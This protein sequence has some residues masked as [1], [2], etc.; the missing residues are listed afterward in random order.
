MGSELSMKTRSSGIPPS[1]MPM[2]AMLFG[3]APVSD[4]SS[5]MNSGAAALLNSRSRSLRAHDS[6]ATYQT[7]V[8]RGLRTWVTS[9]APPGRSSSH[10]GDVVLARRGR[11]S[12]W[13]PTR[14]AYRRRPARTGGDSSRR[15]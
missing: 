14:P 4:G 10:A 12:D 2:V 8:V 6:S 15:R 7:D 11:A 1:R 9:D 3:A 13:P 5:V